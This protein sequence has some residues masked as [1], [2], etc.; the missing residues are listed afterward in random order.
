MSVI[1]TEQLLIDGIVLTDFDIHY[2]RD[3]NGSVLETSKVAGD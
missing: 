1:L 2:R 3:A